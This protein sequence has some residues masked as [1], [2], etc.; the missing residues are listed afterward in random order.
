MEHERK[1]RANGEGRL[2]AAKVGGRR[3]KRLAR[4]GFSV[5]ERRFPAAG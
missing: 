5:Y 3:R 1:F 4:G 2:F